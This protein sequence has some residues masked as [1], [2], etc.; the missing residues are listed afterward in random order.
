[1]SLVELWRTS[2]YPTNLCSVFS[3]NPDHDL[4]SENAQLFMNQQ[5]TP[6]SDSQRFIPSASTSLTR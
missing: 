4:S 6:G 1:M 2:G 5:Q 3:Q